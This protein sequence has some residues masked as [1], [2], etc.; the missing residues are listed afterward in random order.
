VAQSFGQQ[1]KWREAL[2]LYDRGLDY[3]QKAK[4]A[5]KKVKI[6]DDNGHVSNFY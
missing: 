5:L 1:K 4:Q 6:T 3:A 2:A